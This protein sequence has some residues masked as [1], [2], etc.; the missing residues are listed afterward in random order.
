MQRYEGYDNRVK[1]GINKDILKLIFPYCEHLRNFEFKYD[2]F[3]K[4]VSYSSSKKESFLAISQAISPLDQILKQKSQ[5]ELNC[6]AEL[7]L[8]ETSQSS[9]FDSSMNKD[10]SDVQTERVEIDDTEVVV[11]EDM[12]EGFKFDDLSCS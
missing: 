11:S 6:E 3:R 2:L 9:E 10:P 12:I 8:K 1:K 7:R 5:K 4:Y